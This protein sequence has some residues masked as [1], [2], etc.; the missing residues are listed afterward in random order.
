MLS[1]PHSKLTNRRNSPTITGWKANYRSRV[2][3]CK[4]LEITPL[5]SMPHF[6]TY[7]VPL[8]VTLLLLYRPEQHI[9]FTSCLY[10]WRARSSSLHAWPSSPHRCLISA[11]FAVLGNEI[12]LS[13]IHSCGVSHANEASNK[14]A[15]AFASWGTKVI[16]QLVLTWDMQ[17]CIPS[18]HR[19]ES[20]STM[21]VVLNG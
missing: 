4:S 17:L 12:D 1:Y 7:A 19:F 10:D 13:P 2:N 8:N 16:C 20:I 21:R 6:N 18:I 15:S 14:I 3:L 9:C 5:L 11:F